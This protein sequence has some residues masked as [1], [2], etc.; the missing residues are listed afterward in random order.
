MCE[1]TDDTDDDD[2]A[3]WMSEGRQEALE[4]VLRRYGPEVNGWLRDHYRS[5]HAT[6]LDDVFTEAAWKVWTKADTFDKSKGTLGGWFLTIAQRKAM[7]A[8][9]GRRR[10]RKRFTQEEEFNPPEDCSISDDTPLS[11]ET[12]KETKRLDQIIETKLKGH[13]QFIV[14]ADMEAGDGVADNKWLAERLGSTPESIMVSR[15]KAHK[16]I[17]KHWQDSQAQ[18]EKYRGKK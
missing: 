15:N 8:A 6:E 2:L 1:L 18:E 9:K 11:K 5:F 14:R 17:L 13:Q 3:Y 10:H 4:I 12:L 16:N 7:D